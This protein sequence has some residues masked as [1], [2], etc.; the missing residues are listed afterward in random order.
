MSM[1]Q[2]TISIYLMQA[3]SYQSSFNRRNSHEMTVTDKTETW[4]NFKLESLKSK[5]LTFSQR[6]QYSLIRILIR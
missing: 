2:H 5:M 6:L 1:R 4:L 3:Y